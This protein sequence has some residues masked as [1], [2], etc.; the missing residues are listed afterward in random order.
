[1][2]STLSLPSLISV[3]TLAV[4]VDSNSA[5]ADSNLS[6][7]CGFFAVSGTG[8]ID[9]GSFQLAGFEAD[10]S[11]TPLLLDI[12]P[13]LQSLS[14]VE[15][16]STNTTLFALQS[17]TLYTN[18]TVDSFEIA[19]LVSNG[20]IISFFNTPNQVVANQFCAIANADPAGGIPDPTL[21]LLGDPDSFSICKTISIPPASAV[22]Y[23]ASANN[24]NYNIDDCT[25][26]Q[27]R[28]LPPP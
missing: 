3:A 15:V 26:V 17:G 16:D 2:F 10:N 19:S 20:T 14:V 5:L 27:I 8:F 25:Q 6:Q 22:V 24:P 11:T 23:N 4:A 7:D 28:L 21:A 1:M 13:L 18:D 12:H 9:A